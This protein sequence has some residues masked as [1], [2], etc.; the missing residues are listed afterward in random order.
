[1]EKFGQEVNFK[2]SRHWI[3]KIEKRIHLNDKFENAEKDVGLI[4]VNDE[5]YKI[6]FMARVKID[7]ICQPKGKDVWLLNKEFIRIYRILFK[8]I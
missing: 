3:T 2:D 7:E 4:K 8:K 5:N 6:L 1:M